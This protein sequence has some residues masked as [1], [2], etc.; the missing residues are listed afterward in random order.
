M[1]GGPAHARA[2]GGEVQRRRARRANRPT[3]GTPRGEMVVA[4]TT[5][6]GCGW[7]TARARGGGGGGREGRTG[8][9]RTGNSR[10]GRPG[11]RERWPP[12]APYT[13]STTARGRAGCAAAGCV[14]AGGVAA[15]A[16]THRSVARGRARRGGRPNG[17]FPTRKATS[18]GWPGP[19]NTPGSEPCL[20]AVSVALVWA[21]GP[22]AVCVFL[23]WPVFFRM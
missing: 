23:F 13:A 19:A 21:F 7:S 2:G 11:G 10:R 16:T 20:P 17:Q 9:R 15:K 8:C 18:T 22:R 6:P 1:R 5:W 12:P 3:D 14:R 4:E